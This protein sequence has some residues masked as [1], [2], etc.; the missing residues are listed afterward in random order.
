MSF[1]INESHLGPG[2]TKKDVAEAIY[3]L[4]GFGWEVRYGDGPTW[5]EALASDP[6]ERA[7]FEAD[8]K[9]FVKS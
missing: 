8:L 9:P 4:E 1:F 2:A 3:E 5:K 6:D 7:A